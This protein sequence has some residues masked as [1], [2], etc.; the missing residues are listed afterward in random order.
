MKNPAN[1]LVQNHSYIQ[2]LWAK[3][4]TDDNRLFLIQ[5]FDET[6]T[7]FVDLPSPYEIDLIRVAND[8]FDAGNIVR[9]E[10][11]GVRLAEPTAYEIAM[12]FVK[13]LLACLKEMSW[14]LRHNVEWCGV[15]GNR[16]LL[17]EESQNLIH[18]Y[19][20]NFCLE[21]QAMVEKELSRV[22]L[23]QNNSSALRE[24]GFKASEADAHIAHNHK[25]FPKK[26]LLDENLCKLA[27]S[28][29]RAEPVKRGDKI[30]LAR[31]ITGEHKGDAPLAV[32]L[33]TQMRMAHKRGEVRRFANKK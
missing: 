19:D 8:H 4:P 9:V 21:L 6:R 10:V 17:G 15:G 18:R 16:D 20:L 3:K 33:L 31:E 26:K 7:A 1:Y 11:N 22:N 13:D 30:R 12:V 24:V 23:R 2:A 27:L 28:L 25:L 5:S 14:L 29:E 32:S